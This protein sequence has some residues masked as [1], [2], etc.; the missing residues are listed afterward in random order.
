MRDY[1]PVYLAKQLRDAGLRRTPTT[2]DIFCSDE[3]HPFLHPTLG[4]TE[5]YEYSIVDSPED[6]G[7]PYLESYYYWLPTDYD[8][9]LVL[10][11]RGLTAISVWGNSNT[12]PQT[13]ICTCI[14][15]N[16]SD[17]DATTSPV[18]CSSSSVSEVEAVGKALLWVLTSGYTSKSETAAPDVI[19]FDRKYT[20]IPT[21]LISSTLSPEDQ[22]R[23]KSLLRELEYA[24]AESGEG[25]SA[26]LVVK[27]DAPYAR[28]VAEIMR[29]YGHYCDTGDGPIKVG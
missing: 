6:P 29:E 28:K 1:T 8:L 3:A 24:Q 15:S 25:D 16:S 17:E 13:P 2:G 22:Y 9:R 26:Y 12:I 14:L 11:F 10:S 4:V 21:K 23:L 20:V 27:T 5:G 7:I 19:T 18:Y